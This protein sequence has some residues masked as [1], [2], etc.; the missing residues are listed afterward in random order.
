[1][2]HIQNTLYVTQDGAAYAY[3]FRR[4]LSELYLVEGLK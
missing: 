3:F 4:L 2:K 1:M